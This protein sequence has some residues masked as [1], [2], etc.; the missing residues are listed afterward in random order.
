MTLLTDFY[1]RGNRARRYVPHEENTGRNESTRD[2]GGPVAQMTR[3]KRLLAGPW[4]KAVEPIHSKPVIDT[5]FA[6]AFTPDRS[7]K[8]RERKFLSLLPIYRVFPVAYYCES[9]PARP[10]LANETSR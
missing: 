9:Q 4:P 8:P 3:G 5:R 10:I 7:G 1:G 6:E 2:I